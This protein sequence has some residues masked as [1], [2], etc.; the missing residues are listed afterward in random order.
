MVYQDF[1]QIKTFLGAITGVGLQPRED[2]GIESVVQ[3]VRDL[4]GGLS[5]GGGGEETPSSTERIKLP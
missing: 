3:N 5:G 4:I 1:P 2:Q